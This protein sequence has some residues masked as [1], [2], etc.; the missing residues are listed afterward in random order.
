M[1]LAAADPMIS[2][3]SAADMSRSL[4]GYAAATRA[5]LR[6]YLDGPTPAPYLDELLSDYPG[7]GGKMLRPAI[8][9][10]NAQ[11]FGGSGGSAA[12]CAAA[13]EIL[14]NGLLIHDD[15]QD[16]SELRRGRPTL[17]VLHGTPLAINAGDALMF[18]A[19]RPLIDALRPLGG[20]VARQVLDVTLNMAR[21]TA[22]GQA[23][24]LGWRDRN[25]TDLSA[26]DYFRMALKKTA[27]MGMIW[28]A[29]LGLIVG[30]LGRADPER[31]VRFGYFL[32]LAFQV[33]DDLRNLS[34]DPGYGKERNG[35]LY[36]GKRTLMLIHVRSACDS[37]ERARMD[38]FLDQR[39]ED[40]APADIL[41]L[42]SLMER[43][44]S[45]AYAREVAAAMGGAAAHEFELAYG[46]LPAS[47]DRDFLGGLVEWVFRRS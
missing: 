32:G 17:H 26:Q 34:V 18:T 5:E 29:Q 12:R 19:L 23:L 3:P 41:W 43:C 15:I 36:E 37:Q 39:R 21:E 22:E 45:I 28:P 42:A 9:L 6:R 13:V 11:V 24:E 46:G 27:W 35:D 7:R 30:S 1:T 25:V 16:L 38:A 33:E 31:V 47:E 14:H 20:E 10:A 4:A 8:C 44:G 2:R 40:R